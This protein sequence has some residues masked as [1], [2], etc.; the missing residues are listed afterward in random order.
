MKRRVNIMG[1][2][3]NTSAKKS[4]AKN[5]ETKISTTSCTTPL[6]AMNTSDDEALTAIV[7]TNLKNLIIQQSMTQKEL[8]EITGYCEAAVCRYFRGNQFP[9][10]DF[11]FKLKKLYDISIDDF[12]SR[13]VFEPVIETNEHETEKRR[14]QEI[15]ELDLYRKYCGNYIVYY[16]DTSNYKGRD[17][18]TPAEAL[19]YGVINIHEVHTNLNKS[20]F[21]T[22]AFLGIDNREEATALKGKLDS[23]TSIEEINAFV[24]GASDKASQN[25]I[26][27]GDFEFGAKHAYISLK[28]DNIDRALIVLYRVETNKPY[29]N[30]G[31]GVINSGSKGREKMP[32]A[33]FMAFSRFPITLSEEEIHHELLLTY[34]SFKADNE[35]KEL[36]AMFKNTYLAPDSVTSKLSDYQKELMLKV[37][38]EDSIKKIIEKN[39]DRYAK[40]SERDDSNWYHLLKEEEKKYQEKIKAQTN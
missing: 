22:I 12:I 9:P 6:A 37:C 16:L 2:I 13:P 10:I 25:N 28:H 40:T 32:T 26:Y 15:V 27:T 8:A 14:L 33:Q 24:Y 29:Y 23:L 19:V 18:N 3:K 38:I 36:V 21:E 5:V 7:T 39:L 11:L 1:T 20:E 31:L 30:G 4:T 17:F 35:V 34:P